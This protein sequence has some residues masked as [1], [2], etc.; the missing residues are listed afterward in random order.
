MVKRYADFG[1]S[2]I[3]R[4]FIRFIDFLGKSVCTRERTHINS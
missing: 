1:N 2:V 3:G 4:L